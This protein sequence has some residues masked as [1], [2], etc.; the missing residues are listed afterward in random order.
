MLRQS[1]PRNVRLAQRKYVQLRFDITPRQVGL[2]PQFFDKYLAGQKLT[3][4]GTEDFYYL[5]QDPSNPGG[6][7]L[8]IHNNHIIK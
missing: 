2:S 4:V 6:K 8:M 5:V 7:P 1:L 3:V